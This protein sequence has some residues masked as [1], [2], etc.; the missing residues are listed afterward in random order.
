M[1]ENRGGRLHPRVTMATKR[2]REGKMLRLEEDLTFSSDRQQLCS[3][4]IRRPGTHRDEETAN[5]IIG[6]VR[7][8]GP[9][10]VFTGVWR[11]GSA[12]RLLAN[13]E[14]SP[15]MYL[16]TDGRTMANHPTIPKLGLV[17]AQV[18]AQFL[19]P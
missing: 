4:R 6:K 19:A 13:F 15:W 12:G 14:H 17:V 3:W 5:D 16:R 7:G 2:Q 11:R 9:G 18:T 8:R 10:N 1:T